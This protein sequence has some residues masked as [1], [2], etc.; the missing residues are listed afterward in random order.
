MWRY[1]E[2]C[3]RC[4]SCS[5]LIP[6]V[7]ALHQSRLVTA[8]ILL[9]NLITSVLVHGVEPGTENSGQSIIDHL[10]R[11]MKLSWAE[12]A[13]NAA[14]PRQFYGF[15]DNAAIVAWIALNT[16]LTMEGVIHGR[17]VG[18]A[19]AVTCAVMV[20]FTDVGPRFVDLMMRSR[21]QCHVNVQRAHTQVGGITGLE[22]HAALF[23]ILQ[24]TALAVWGRCCSSS[25]LAA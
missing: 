17:R 18:I 14:G 13:T 4:S 12:L 2:T 5:F 11:D 9:A 1:S 15:L 7:V 20:A 10:R 22:H 3:L 19:L 25:K 24:C 16:G 21:I 6:L 8:C 23:F